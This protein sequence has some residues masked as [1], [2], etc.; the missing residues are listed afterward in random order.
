MSEVLHKAVT[1]LNLLK[2]KNGCHEW[3]AAELARLSGYNHATTHRILQDMQ[4]YGLVGQNRVTKKFYLGTTIAEL[5][6]LAGGYFSIRDIARPYMEEIAQITKETVYLNVI[7]SEKESLLI[8]SI[9]SDHQLRIVEPLGLRLPLHIGATRRVILAYMSQESQARYL[10]ECDWTPRTDQGIM[11][12]QDFKEDLEK[13]REKGYAISSGETTIGTWGIS[14][15]LFGP[16]GVEGSLCIAS[17]QLRVDE[18][19]VRQFA[20]ILLQKSQLI[21]HA[22]GGGKYV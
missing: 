17:P 7:I 19:R 9:D 8:D 13:I 22:L 3:G 1:L 16:E 15:P 21:S 14:V 11:N 6:L 20:D 4:K 12:E 18:E 10:S 2:P 5:G